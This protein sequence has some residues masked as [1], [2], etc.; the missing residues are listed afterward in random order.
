MYIL[1]TYIKHSK[2]YFAI[3]K[4]A[5]SHTLLFIEYV[6]SGMLYFVDVRS[7]YGLLKLLLNFSFFFFI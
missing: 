2:E 5:H 3:E 4:K 6:P 7:F 1:V